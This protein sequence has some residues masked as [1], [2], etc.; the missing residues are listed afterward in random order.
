MKKIL[1][2]FFFCIFLFSI[3][4]PLFC[5]EEYPSLI[6]Q[7]GTYLNACLNNEKAELKKNVLKLKWP[8]QDK[9][10]KLIETVLCANNNE[11]SRSYISDLVPNKLRRKDLTDAKPKIM[12][13][14]KNEEL[15]NKL[16]ALR[17]AWS[18]N[19]R[20]HETNLYQGIVLQYFS[21]EACVKELTLRHVKDKWKLYEISETCD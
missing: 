20:K 18:P 9:A 6:M 12:F 7:G 19:V 17:N 10:W 11:I 4:T 2:I 3:S 14:R 21:N 8:N 15:I 5:Q 13:V 1:R 16:L